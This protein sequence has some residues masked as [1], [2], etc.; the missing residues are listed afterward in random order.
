ME[1]YDITEWGPINLVRSPPSRSTPN[2]RLIRAPFGVVFNPAA[3]VLSFFVCS[4]ISIDTKTPDYRRAD[5]VISQPIPA[6]TRTACIFLVSRSKRWCE[7]R[8][9]P[10]NV[11]GRAHH[12]KTLA[13]S[14]R[15]RICAGQIRNQ[16]D[17]TQFKR[18]MR[19]WEVK[20]LRISKCVSH[21]PPACIIFWRAVQIARRAP[22]HGCVATVEI[23]NLAP[24]WLNPISFEHQR[25]SW[26]PIDH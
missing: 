17:S 2:Q 5:A 7:K 10:N 18:F 12:L 15:R 6:P 24:A 9:G 23:D 4:N 20:M 21:S 25:C 8:S 26:A 13:V 3:A 14:P 22:W 1:V 19:A 11:F 16:I